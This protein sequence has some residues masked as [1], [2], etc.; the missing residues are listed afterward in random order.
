MKFRLWITCLILSLGVPALARAAGEWTIDDRLK[1]HFAFFV[2]EEPRD[3][4]PFDM[5]P[6][7]PVGPGFDPS[8]PDITNIDLDAIC[9]LGFPFPNRHQPGKFTLY[10]KF[11][12][13]PESLSAFI[14]TKRLIDGFLLHRLPSYPR[15]R[16]YLI[17]RDN[18]RVKKA[19]IGPTGYPF[20]ALTPY[21]PLL[22]PRHGKVV[23]GQAFSSQAYFDEHI[24]FAS[25]Y[26][27][28][29]APP[30]PRLTEE[31]TVA[32]S[33]M[34]VLAFHQELLE[35]YDRVL[36]P[37]EGPDGVTHRAFRVPAAAGERTV[38]ILRVP[39]EP[40]IFTQN[41]RD[42]PMPEDPERVFLSARLLLHREEYDLTGDL[43]PDAAPG[44]PPFQ[45]AT[46]LRRAQVFEVGSVVRRP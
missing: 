25:L 36:E 39:R 6:P 14:S 20:T 1:F 16:S 10:L 23:E 26:L 24:P 11:F 27:E 17:R 13:F 3:P 7:M 12:G 5:V 31:E 42:L 34:G 38:T 29:A 22:I 35:A 33:G 30:P 45:Q 41:W 4:R 9:G 37:N 40:M 8:A 19:F 43:P 2:A 32:W 18:L 15:L 46:R 28:P 44:S 21:P